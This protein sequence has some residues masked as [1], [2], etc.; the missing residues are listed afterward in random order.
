VAATPHLRSDHPDVVPAQLALRCAELNDTLATEGLRLEVVPGGESDLLWALNAP[1]EELALVSYAQRGTDLLVETP[2]G[3]LP[4][5]FEKLLFRL[6]KRGYRVLLAHPE[7]NITFQREPGRLTELARR[8]VL[9][10]VTASSLASGS[11]RSGTA[12]LAFSLVTEGVC[13]VIASDAH[14]AASGRASLAQGLAAAG[15]LAPAR[16]DWMVSVAPAAILAG[17]P[18]PPPPSEPRSRW[19]GLRRAL[20]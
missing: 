2:H 20:R 1:D 6:G 8:G 15:E 4:P 17:E 18:L 14:G 10:Q 11:R 19:R 12:R 16:S 3:P 13:H 9:L 5:G 7:R